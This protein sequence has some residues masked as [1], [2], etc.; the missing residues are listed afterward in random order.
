MFSNVADATVAVLALAGK[1]VKFV[2]SK[3]AGRGCTSAGKEAGP[4]G[5]IKVATPIHGVA[6]THF[7]TN[8]PEGSANQITE[9]PSAFEANKL[10]PCAKAY[11]L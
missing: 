10:T 9:P 6:V 11:P 3:V 5:L 4:S 8:S 1:Y 7:C 2:T